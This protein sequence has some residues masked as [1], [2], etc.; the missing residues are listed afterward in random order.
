MPESG[1][2][3]TSFWAE[4]LHLMIS[5]PYI[6]CFLQISFLN[7]YIFY[8]FEIQLLIFVKKNP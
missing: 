3:H 4:Y 2:L 6:L 8:G 5:I 7:Y 1:L